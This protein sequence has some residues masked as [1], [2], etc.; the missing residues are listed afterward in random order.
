MDFVRAGG[1]RMAGSLGWRWRWYV[2]LV[3]YG[4]LRRI[5]AH[6]CGLVACCGMA[7]ERGVSAY[8]HNIGGCISPEGRRGK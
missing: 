2:L 7:M 8:G 5:R 4:V 6:A 3:G 1:G